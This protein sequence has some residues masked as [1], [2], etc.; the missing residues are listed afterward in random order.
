ML[1][2]PCLKI[3]DEEH[4]KRTWDIKIWIRFLWQLH[5]EGVVEE[6]LWQFLSIPLHWK[7]VPL[8]LSFHKS[9][10]HIFNENLSVTNSIFQF[11]LSHTLKNPLLLVL[12]IQPTTNKFLFKLCLL[13]VTLPIF[14]TIQSL[15]FLSPFYQSRATDKIPSLRGTPSVCFSVI[16]SEFPHLCLF[17]G[18]IFCPFVILIWILCIF[19]CWIACVFNKNQAHLIWVCVEN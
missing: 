2:L 13:H 16:Y 3:E 7:L 9:I 18:C 4:K 14:R 15:N 10:L 6:S 5:V 17:P 12:L 8:E 19:F 1:D 11:H